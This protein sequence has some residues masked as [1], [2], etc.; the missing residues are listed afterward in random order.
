MT[1]CLAAIAKED[2]KEYI[3]FSTDHMVTTSIGQFEHSIIKYKEINKTTVAML[4]G[5]PLLFDDLINIKNS[6]SLSYL[7]IQKQ[8]FDNFKKKRK[9]IIQNEIFDVYG[10]EQ[11]FFIDALARP[12]P[13]PHIHSIL[14]EVS[15]FNLGTGILLIGFEDNS[16]RI[17]EVNE[18]GVLNFRDM[19]FH[20]IGSG[21]MQ[22]ANTMLFQK[23]D[24]CEAL[25]STVYNV[26]KSKK[27]AEVL[28]GVGRETELLVLSLNGCKKLNG[29]DLEIL[30]KIYNNELSFGKKHSDLSK[31]DLGSD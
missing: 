15:K 20:A 13:N 17:S 9:E 16:A 24:K 8:V 28:E 7:E 23:H 18:R 12:I 25:T 11:K 14:E 29:S 10:I 1:I 21:N 3:V 4:A 19:N 26:F 30:N 27:N 5:D 6:N 22:A 2:G 31:I